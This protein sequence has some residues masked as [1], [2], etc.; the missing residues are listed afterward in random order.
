MIPLKLKY[1]TTHVEILFITKQKSLAK[2]KLKEVEL[3]PRSWLLIEEEK[4]TFI[5][6]R[7]KTMSSFKAGLKKEKILIPKIGRQLKSKY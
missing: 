6:L 2:N 3:I 7:Q 1:D 4:L 5:I